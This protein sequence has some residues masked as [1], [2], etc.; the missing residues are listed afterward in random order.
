M[1]NP[2]KYKNE[3]IE[4]LGAASQLMNWYSD[5]KNESIFIC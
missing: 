2:D 3:I 5:F 1:K 4:S